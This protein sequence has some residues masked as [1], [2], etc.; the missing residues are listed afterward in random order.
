MT[1]IFLPLALVKKT[2]IKN[3]VCATLI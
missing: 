3:L 1:S 2:D